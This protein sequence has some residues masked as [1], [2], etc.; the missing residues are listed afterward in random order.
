MPHTTSLA[1]QRS[2]NP[3]TRTALFDTSPFTRKLPQTPSLQAPSR[4]GGARTLATIPPQ[5]PTPA[6]PIAA[7]AAFGPDGPFLISSDNPF[8]VGRFFGQT[9]GTTNIP[10]INALSLGEAAQRSAGVDPALL[11]LED[12]RRNDRL[13]YARALEYIRPDPSRAVGTGQTAEAARLLAGAVQNNPF[14]S[15]AGLGQ[16]QR[17]VAP[18][19][20]QIDPAFFRHTSPVIV[21]SL[22]GLLQSFGMRPEDVIFQQQAA[23]PEGF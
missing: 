4:P 19:L 9:G 23:R 22:L 15:I 1:R 20:N 8:T 17:G 16:L 21:Q 2:K 10:T 18:L 7:T 5:L 11:Q 12:L 14:I 3:Q 13:G 6:T